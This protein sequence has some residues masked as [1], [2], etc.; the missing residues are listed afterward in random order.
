M[1]NVKMFPVL[2]LSYSAIL[3]GVIVT[4]AS[5]G[6]LT[7]PSLAIVPFVSALPVDVVFASMPF[8]SASESAKPELASANLGGGQYD[9]FP[10][11]LTVKLVGWFRRG[12]GRNQAHRS[13]L[14]VASLRAD[15]DKL[16]ANLKWF[17]GKWPTANLTHQDGFDHQLLGPKL[18]GALAAA[19][20]LPPM[21]QPTRISEVLLSAVR[22]SGFYHVH[23][24]A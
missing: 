17:S 24:I 9:V 22:T 6:A 7:F 13:S 2:G 18:I 23:S 15:N 14:M 5:T 3:A 8:R 10:A 19:S 21:F 12:A 11:L 1:V 20:G 4:L 16:G